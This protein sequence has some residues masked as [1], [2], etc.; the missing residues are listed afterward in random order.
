MDPPS[1][2][3]FAVKGNERL[4]Y[5]TNHVLNWLTF[6]LRTPRHG[7][8]VSL[9]ETGSSLLHNSGVRRARSFELLLSLLENFLFVVVSQLFLMKFEL[10][11]A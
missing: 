3:N 8:G 10:S 5:L 9:R 6:F 7:K 11:P 1:F 4:V 2:Q